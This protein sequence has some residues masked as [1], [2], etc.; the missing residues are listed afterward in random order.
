MARCLVFSLAAAL[1]TATPAVADQI[2]GS[3]YKSGNWDGGAY[4]DGVAFSHCA[5]SADYKSGIRLHF[6]I[7]R[8]Y[9]WRMGFSHENWTMQDGETVPIRY[10]IDKNE[11]NSVSANVI[12]PNF[13]MAELI[14]KDYL[15][16]QFRRGRVLKVEAGGQNYSFSL[17]GTSRALSRTLKC[18]NDYL[19]YSVPVAGAPALAPAPVAKA[20]QPAPMP[21]A[22]A[23]V[24]RTEPPASNV[25]R[26]PG[27]AVLNTPA[28]GTAPKTAVPPPEPPPAAAK[29]AITEAVPKTPAFSGGP[30]P[31]PK[32][33]D[34]P[35]REV[36]LAP[37]PRT[38]AA[39]P[40]TPAAPPA[41]PAATPPAE[42]P[43]AAFANSPQD[44]LDATRFVIAM[45]ASSEF[46][47]FQL[48]DQRS[49]GEDA[50]NFLKTA[51]VGWTSPGTR[52]TLHVFKA[53]STTPDGVIADVIA[54][55]SRNCDGSFASGKKPAE[56]DPAVATAFT[57]CKAGE[58]Y[59]FY[60]DYLTFEAA[61][62]QIYMMS[63]LQ[64][65]S[66]EVDRDVSETL[67]RN[68]A[69]VRQ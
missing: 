19:D 48:T 1:L 47:G 45:F 9:L 20:P 57:A 10:Q 34:T 5:I 37:P 11:V 54:D 64:S 28:A 40:A 4:G 65:A 55:D 67:A 13:V 33:T 68:V 50:P 35:E 36:A 22:P 23:V 7:D 21:E 18:V 14:A 32:A 38:P 62:G 51:A 12:T 42:E 15:F 49:L 58:T 2:R 26:M 52:G 30:E 61:S 69:L 56:D 63:S 44:I 53:G 16:N 8:N 60:V 29:I 39:P 43:G 31:L 27:T 24:A 46:A 66:S 6:A 25:P 41:K 3:A 17:T 59:K